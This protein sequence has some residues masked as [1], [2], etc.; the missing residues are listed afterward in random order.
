MGYCAAERYRRTTSLRQAKGCGEWGGV[1]G[2]WGRGPFGK[3]G[4]CAEL[5]KGR[6]MMV[7]VCVCVWAWV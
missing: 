2:G 1:R 7:V 3:R 6:V 4:G 5:N